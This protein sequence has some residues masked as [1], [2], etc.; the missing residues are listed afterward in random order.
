MTSRRGNLICLAA[1]T[2]VWGAYC[3]PWLAGGQIIPYDAKNHFYPMIRFLA[4]AW[5]GGE[6]PF[7]S[8]Y[9]YAGFPMIADPQSVIWTPTFWIPIALSEAP[10]MWLVDLVHQ[11]HLLVGAGAIFAFGRLSG[12][13]AEAALI[14]A[15]S[16]MMAG[17]VSVRMEHLL[18]TVSYTWLAVALWRL[19]AFLRFGGLWR[20]L[21]FGVPLGAMLIDRDHVAYLGAWFLLFYWLTRIIGLPREEGAWPTFRRQGAFVAGGCFALLLAALPVLLLLQLAGESNRPAFGYDLA[22]WQSLH[23]AALATFLMPEYFG[24]LEVVGAYWGPASTKWGG[25]YLRMHRSMMQHYCG[26]LILVLLAWH[27][28]RSGQ[29]WRGQARFLLVAALVS[30]IYAL[31]RYTPVFEGLYTYVPGVDLFRRPADA[32]FLFGLCISLL[33]GVL[34]D[35]AIRQPVPRFG[36]GPCILLAILA[37][38]ALWRLGTL[39][40]EYDRLADLTS[41]LIVLVLLAAGFVLLL[42]RKA[43]LRWRQA[44]V[45]GLVLLHAGDLVYHSSGTAANA[46]SPDAYLP[47]E[48]PDADPLFARLDQLLATP[49]PTGAPWRIETMGLGPTV[50]NIAQVAGYH[51]LLGYNP[52]RLR[53]VETLIGPRMQNNAGYNRRF[54]SR[55]TGYDSALTDQL[56]LRYIVTGRPIAA[57][58][59]SVPPDRFPLIETI[60]RGARTAYVYE[61]PQAIPRAV[62]TDAQGARIE[63]Q[64]RFTTYTHAEMTLSVIAPVAAR[65][66]LHEFDY[67]GWEAAVDGVP[68]PI[69]RHQDL[70]R[71]IELPAG[72]HTVRLRFRPF[73]AAALR[74]AVQS[75]GKGRS[76]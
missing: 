35:A 41:A 24:Q 9:H 12:W 74:A 60:A 55:M 67:P 32:L 40:V 62:L 4:D 49:D 50:Q 72:A 5:H 71:A 17:A 14:A 53:G 34:A 25:E 56:G 8:P 73:S 69:L 30:M 7:W 15:I 75:F 27:A 6:S 10:S 43:D 39:A 61:N 58:D 45:A 47:I 57:I 19:E 65:L 18:M 33:T 70:F 54:G 1:L 48:T 66:V 52:L 76:Q 16:Y 13:R 26:T 59:P 11:L 42:R 3:W 63:G 64:V 28:M 20:G 31:G 22:S 23:P 51:N 2:L 21:A 29:L 36:V 46:R 44:A 37:G 38:L 68:V